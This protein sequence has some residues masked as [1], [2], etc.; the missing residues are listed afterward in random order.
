MERVVDIEPGDEIGEERGNCK[1]RGKVN[2]KQG[3]SGCG[4]V[5]ERAE[6]K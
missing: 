6:K 5:Q 4:F 3:K 1:L 2:S